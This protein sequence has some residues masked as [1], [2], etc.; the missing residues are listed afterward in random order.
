MVRVRLRHHRLLPLPIEVHVTRRSAA[1]GSLVILISPRSQRRISHRRLGCP[2]SQ[3][4]GEHNS[5]HN[6]RH[7]DTYPLD[8]ETIHITTSHNRLHSAGFPP[9]KRKEDNGVFF[10]LIPS[11]EKCNY[12]PDPSQISVAQHGHALRP[13]RLC[14]PSRGLGSTEMKHSTK[15]RKNNPPP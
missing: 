10:I 3:R 6:K 14:P 9:F 7:S 8:C 4:G 5:N 15:R 2:G 1:L 13:P 11:G 12:V